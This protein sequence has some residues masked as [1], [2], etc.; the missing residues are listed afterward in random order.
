MHSETWEF[1]RFEG[2]RAR[3]SS[4]LVGDFFVVGATLLCNVTLFLF[5]HQFHFVDAG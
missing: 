1:Q 3:K 5:S 4:G 2:R